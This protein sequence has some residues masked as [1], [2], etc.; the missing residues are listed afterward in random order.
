MVVAFNH[1]LSKSTSSYNRAGNTEEQRRVRVSRMEIRPGHD[2][3]VMMHLLSRSSDGTSPH[4][5]DTKSILAGIARRH[6]TSYLIVFVFLLL[7]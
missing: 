4:S 7:Y 3:V 5:G 6:A 2:A 1:G